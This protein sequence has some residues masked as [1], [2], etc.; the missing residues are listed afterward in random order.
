MNRKK[1]EETFSDPKKIV[2]FQKPPLK[3]C[4]VFTWDRKEFF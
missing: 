2:K 1:S 3:S 4:P